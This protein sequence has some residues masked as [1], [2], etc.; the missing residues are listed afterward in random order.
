MA[1]EDKKDFNAML[2]NSKDMPKINVI[3]NERTI[4][5]NGGDHML[6]APPL[7]YDAL[8]KQVPKGKVALV[9][10]LRAKL[11]TDTGAD[12]TDPMTAGMFTS[13]AAWASY[14]RTTGTGPNPASYGN[15]ETP[16][17]RTL[18]AEG[19]LNPKF[20]GGI[21]KQREL[22]EAEGHTI[23]QRGRKNLRYFVEDYE[24]SRFTF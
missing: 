22:L 20:P 21:E 18:K 11:A 16:W 4:E 24:E 12:F 3:T 23:V 8:M 10:D 14:Q 2:R 6:L 9:S 1:N 19:E 5:R 15:E 13:I 17:W 7:A